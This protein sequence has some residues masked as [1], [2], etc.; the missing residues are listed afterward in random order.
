MHGLSSISPAS[1]FCLTVLCICRSV[2]FT[3]MCFSMVTPTSVFHGFTST[4]S[5]SNWPSFHI[6]FP[7][8]IQKNYEWPVMYQILIPGPISC[9][10]DSKWQV[11]W[12]PFPA[13]LWEQLSKKKKDRKQAICVMQLLQL[14]SVGNYNR[15][16]YGCLSSS[17]SPFSENVCLAYL[18]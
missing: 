11:V 18:Y 13:R 7:N 14:K 1:C 12:Y 4:G 5:M 10:L 15:S 16:F 6:P 17:L 3:W 9:Y 8:L 2:S